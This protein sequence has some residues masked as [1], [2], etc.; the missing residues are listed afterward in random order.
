[1][2]HILRETINSQ[3][4]HLLELKQKFQKELAKLYIIRKIYMRNKDSTNFVERNFS[5][6]PNPFGNDFNQ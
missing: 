2:S 6:F 4:S 3:I 1:M 5:I